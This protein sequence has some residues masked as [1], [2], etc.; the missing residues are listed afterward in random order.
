M[1]GPLVVQAT[2]TPWL[3]ACAFPMIGFGIVSTC[4]VATRYVVPHGAAARLYVVTWTVHVT[5]G[6][7][8]HEIVEK[9]LGVAKFLIELSFPWLGFINRVDGHATFKTIISRNMFV[10]S[11]GRA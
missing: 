3:V 6:A 7:N 9:L 1:I 10:P 8:K 11:G 4:A 2:Q 5:C